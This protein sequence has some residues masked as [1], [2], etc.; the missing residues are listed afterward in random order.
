[1]CRQFLMRKSGIYI[2]YI[3]GHKSNSTANGINLQLCTHYFVQWIFFSQ[4]QF[5]FDISTISIQ[6]DIFF[7]FYPSVEGVKYI[8]IGSS[9]FFFSHQN[10]SIEILL[11]YLFI[12]GFAVCYCHGIST[13]YILTNHIFHI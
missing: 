10:R 2:T 7:P 5:S 12:S 11:N 9:G 8:E 13:F 1:M 3:R 4:N 6:I